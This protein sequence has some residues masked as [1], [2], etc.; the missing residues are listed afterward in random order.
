MKSFRS[1]ITLFFSVFLLT[2]GVSVSGAFHPAGTNT[3]VQ[4]GLEFRFRYDVTKG[5]PTATRTEEPHMDYARVRLRPWLQAGPDDLFVKLRLANEFRYYRR[6]ESRDR[7]QRFP[8]VTFIDNLFLHRENLLEDLDLTVGRQ[9]LAYG[10]ERILSDGTSG[11]GTR[12]AYFDAVRFVWHADAKRTLD[13]FALYQARTDWLPTLGRTHDNGK[14]PADYDING[15]NQNEGAIGLYWQ[16]RARKE[17][18]YDLYSI[19]KL[20]Q[21]GQKAKYR[22]EGRTAYTHIL[23][24]RLLPQFTET[25]SGEVE[26][27]GQAGSNR[28]L[29]GQGY[30]GL[31]YAPKAACKPAFTGALWGLTGDSDGER[32]RHAW[33]AVFNRE[34]GLGESIA[35]M[36]TKYSYTNILY[37]HLAATVQP[38][39]H[40]ALE[41]QAGH[42]FAPIHEGEAGRSRGA[43]ALIRYRIKLGRLFKSDHLSGGSLAFQGEFFGKGNYFVTG[44]D[45]PAFFGRVEVSWQF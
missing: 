38:A 24:F 45:N 43:F 6:P 10:A 16:D 39:D 37:P 41:A 33:H 2:R 20:E 8:D 29:A 40:S 44:D 35:P 17:F 36:Y 26:L 18:G 28:L 15:C 3:P 27:A 21:R 4:V 42:L 34:T 22:N 31:T 5:L 9:E 23:G 13:A 1:V 19:T 11:D 14:E 7:K 12:A 32:G 25:L 30:A